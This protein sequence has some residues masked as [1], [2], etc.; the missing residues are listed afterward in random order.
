MAISNN[1]IKRLLSKAASKPQKNNIIKALK[2]K[3]KQKKK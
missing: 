3:P 2:P 1:G